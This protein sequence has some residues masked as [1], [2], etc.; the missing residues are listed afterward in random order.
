M[1]TIKKNAIEAYR[2]AKTDSERDLLKTLFGKEL[3]E[4]KIK[5]VED[6]LKAQGL[7]QKEFDLSCEGLDKDEVAYRMLK[8]LTRTLNEGWTPNWNE[9][10]EYKY[11]P[12]FYMD[13]AS[14]FGYDDYHSWI[15]SSS[16]GSRL[17]FK[18]KDLAI[19]AGKTFK[20]TYK[21]FMTL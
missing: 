21:E 7:T 10:D 2:N 11:V 17:C 1:E 6:V 4:T 8:L 16:V 18:T 5:T 15:T 13:D 3:F 12:Y 14:G 19:Y 9:E 20:N